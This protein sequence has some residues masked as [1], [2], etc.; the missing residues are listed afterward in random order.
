MVADIG[1]T[2][3]FL[4]RVRALKV[5]G[6]KGYVGTSNILWNSLS[7]S[8]H[9]CK[10]LLAL[11]ISDSDVSKVHGLGS[12]RR[13]L[14]RLVVHYSMSDIKDLL[15]EGE[16][17]LPISEMEHWACLEEVDFSFNDLKNIDESIQLLGG[18]QKLNIS[19]NN[20]TD[21]GNYLQLLTS[22]T[23]LD[24]SSNGISSV[25]Q[26]NELL[27]NL[28]KLILSNNVIKDVTGLHR[29]YSLEYL[30]L[31]NNAIETVESVSALGGLPCLEILHLSENSVA[32]VVDYRTKVLE[33]FGERHWECL[34][35]TQEF[36][37]VIC[38]LK[39]NNPVYYGQMTV[40][41]FNQFDHFEHFGVLFVQFCSRVKLDGEAPDDR[42]RDTIKL[43]M[44]LR[45]A[46]KEKEEKERK[47]RQ[48]IEE[49]IRYISGNVCEYNDEVESS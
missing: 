28:K 14:R 17:I 42:E 45:R 44:A 29:L 22:L 39:L 49:K 36:I 48:K 9:F 41:V 15:L 16:P 18:V 43:R 32:K 13:T 25:N 37:I 8:L 12:I 3:D 47:R 40:K 46:K 1:N 10:N 21:I 31:R 35:E 26:W 27:G 33:C 7:F 4:H 11:W 5:R 34:N 20:V 24:L 30:D 23:E 19:H 38:A 2:I 6:A